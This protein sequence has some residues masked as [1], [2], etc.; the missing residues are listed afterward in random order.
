MTTRNVDSITAEYQIQLLIPRVYE[1]ICGNCVSYQS[2]KKTQVTT[3]AS[4]I[5]I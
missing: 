2:K 1:L 4:P 3:T 5:S